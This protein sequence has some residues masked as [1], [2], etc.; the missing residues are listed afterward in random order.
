MKKMRLFSILSFVT[1]ITACGAL[2][3]DVQLNYRP[4]LDNDEQVKEIFFLE[5]V[6]SNRNQAKFGDLLGSFSFKNGQYPNTYLF[7]NGD[8]GKT[9]SIIN[10]DTSYQP[11]KKIDANSLKTLNNSKKIKFHELGGEILESIVFENQNGVC[12]SFNS[13][14]TVNIKAVTNYY[15]GNKDSFFATIINMQV[16]KNKKYDLKNI[17]FQYHIANNELK[18]KAKQMAESDQ[19]RQKIIEQDL[20]KQSRILQN[21]ICK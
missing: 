5:A 17:T 19:F 3:K 7:S 10:L 18:N 6:G 4:F 9:I 1:I 14:K 11:L 12:S 21:V 8:V 15:Y 20:D 2:E 16:S 13:G